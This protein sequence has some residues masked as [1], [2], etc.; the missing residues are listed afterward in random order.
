MGRGTV[1][2]SCTLLREGT[3]RSSR[4][5]RCRGHPALPAAPAGGCPRPLPWKLSSSSLWLPVILFSWLIY[6]SALGI[7]LFWIF[8]NICASSINFSACKSD[9]LASFPHAKVYCR[10]R[11]CR[12]TPKLLPL[13][14]VGPGVLPLPSAWRS[15][16]P[17]AVPEFMR[18]LQCPKTCGLTSS[19]VSIH[20]SLGAAWSSQ[21]LFPK[22]ESGRGRGQ[23]VPT[24]AGVVPS[25]T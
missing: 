12:L 2:H 15:P 11:L 3:R 21:Q 5:V 22:E 25:S 4:G 23:F 17:R 19:L 7:C 20:G 13:G 14:C 24:A 9:G 18:G 8:F 16:S 10:H 1:T 6:F